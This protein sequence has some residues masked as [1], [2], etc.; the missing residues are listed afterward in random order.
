MYQTRLFSRSVADGVLQE[1]GR[2]TKDGYLI[3][4]SEKTRRQQL[5]QTDAVDKLRSIVQ[6]AADDRPYEPTTEQLA[7]LQR[8]Y[9]TTLSVSQVE[10]FVH[11][12]AATT[13]AIRYCIYICSQSMS[14]IFDHITITSMIC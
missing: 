6:A 11:I 3:V 13:T 9:I 8:R 2:V 1:S 10:L 7:V 4:T 12:C 14:R 5:N